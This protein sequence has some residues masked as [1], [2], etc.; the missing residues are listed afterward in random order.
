[1]AERSHAIVERALPVVCV[2]SNLSD[3]LPVSVIIAA[4]NEAKNLPRCLD[5]LRG[6]AEVFVV[7]SQSTDATAELAEAAGANVV[8][9]HYAG[10]WPKKRQWALDNLPLC[11]DW[12][13]LLDADESLTPQVFAEMQAA[14]QS[15]G[16]DGYYLGLDMFFLGRRLSH[17]GASFY[18]LAL[19]RRGKGKFECR[20][21]NQ[22]TSMCDM[23]VHEHVIVSGPTRRLKSRLLHYN[24]D[25][26]DRYIHKHNQ[27]S[28]WEARVWSES[29]G[30][31]PQIQPA[32]LGTQVQRRRWLRKR[33]FSLPGSPILFF[34]YK[35]FFRLGFLDGVPGLIYC[36]FQG[37]QFFHIKA[38]I[39]ELKYV[40]TK[41][42]RVQFE[43]PTPEL[44]HVRH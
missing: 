26:L 6:V 25:S 29:G 42:P 33:F 38:K 31:E 24:V 39:Y 8:Q 22:D 5:S 40:P 28:N 11:C 44:T 34:I 3:L 13:L 23:E 10:G 18:K 14:M 37:I 19:F 41:S 36:A 2:R 20:A 9:F 1:M 35:Y 7:D 15:T 30:D 4:K 16:V 27:Y 12:I 21:S 32:L 43:N 17:S